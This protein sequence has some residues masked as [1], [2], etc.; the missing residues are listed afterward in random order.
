MRHPVR[1]AV[2]ELSSGAGLGIP[3]AVDVDA[4]LGLPR[5]TRRPLGSACATSPNPTGPQ[6]LG[7]LSQVQGSDPWAWPLRPRSCAGSGR[8]LLLESANASSRRSSP[9]RVETPWVTTCRR[10]VMS[11]T[12]RAR[13]QSQTRSTSRS[14]ADAPEVTPTVS[15]P[16]SQRSSISVSSSIRC[17]ADAGGARDLDEPV[18]VG[19]VAR[20]DRRAAGRCCAEHLLDGPLAV[21]RRVAD[22]FLLRRLDLREAPAQH[23]DDLGR[24]VDGQRRL[25][26]V[27]ERRVRREL[28]RLG[29]VDVLDEHVASGASPIVPTTSS[30]PCVADQ[31]DRVAVGRVAPR[32]HV[33]LRDERARRVDRVLAALAA[34]RSCTAGA[35]P[36]AEKTTVA[37]RGH[38]GLVLDEDRAPRLEVAHDVRVVD[39]LLADVDGRAV[40][41]ERAARPSRRRA[42]RRR[43]SRAGKLE[44]RA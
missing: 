35:T 22:V 20:A 41:V 10:N 37:P 25:R 27:G 42:R 26:D 8:G 16:S 9:G 44:G 14:G 33:H 31:H 29:V 2:D 12:P 15:T 21:G 3:R 23:R 40:E 7:C 6:R 39:D 38:L 17:D 30:W 36:W 5:P 4:V 24:L 28:E 1:L 18:R 11:V 43:S 13:N 19:R 32:L 34:A